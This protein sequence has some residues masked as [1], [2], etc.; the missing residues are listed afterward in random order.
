MYLEN[1]YQWF[2]VKVESSVGNPENATWEDGLIRLHL[3]ARRESW[4]YEVHRYDL[5]SVVRQEACLHCYKEKI[6]PGKK[7]IYEGQEHR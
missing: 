6:K 4:C 5:S 2:I 3:L 7:K 1:S